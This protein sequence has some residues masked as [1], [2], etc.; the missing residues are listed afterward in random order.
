MMLK[1]RPQFFTMIPREFTTRLWGN[2]RSIHL[3]NDKEYLDHWA[4]NIGFLLDIQFF[5]AA[6]FLKGTLGP[7]EE[8][9]E[10]AEEMGATDSDWRTARMKG[11][12]RILGCRNQR[13]G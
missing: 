10:V 7:I 8:T 12:D 9:V 3:S 4:C 11:E 5:A 6:C 1:L 13:C 2:L